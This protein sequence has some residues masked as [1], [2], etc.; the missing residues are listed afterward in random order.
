MSAG[1][2]LQI[3]CNKTGAT[4]RTVARWAILCDDD[5]QTEDDVTQTPQ[6]KRGPDAIEDELRRTRLELADSI[7]TLTAQV[8][9]ANLAARARRSVVSALQ[10]PDGAWD[11]RKVAAVAGV[12]VVLVVYLVRRRHA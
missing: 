6:D 10:T 5:R 9:P 2:F 4:V 11:P 3:G 1:P 12:A 8:A 7:D